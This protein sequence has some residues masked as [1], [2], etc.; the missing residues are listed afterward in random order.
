MA[1]NGEA[2]YG[3]R[4]GIDVFTTCGHGSVVGNRLYVHAFRYEAP[5]CVFRGLVSPVTK[6]TCLATGKAVAFEQC[7][8]V[9]RMLNLPRKAPDPIATVYRVEVKGE[10]KSDFS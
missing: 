9:V 6:I 8:D 3:T 5:Q 10:L 2:I 7:G 4:R 1:R